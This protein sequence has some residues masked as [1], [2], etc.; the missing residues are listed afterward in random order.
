M[1]D[2]LRSVSK[3]I[4]A[5]Y[6]AWWQSVQE[7]VSKPIL[8]V[9]LWGIGLVWILLL[10]LAVAPVTYDSGPYHEG[11]PV[12]G[13]APVEPNTSATLTSAV[14][15]SQTSGLPSREPPIPSFS[16]ES[17]RSF[18]AQN[19]VSYESIS[20]ETASGERA[21]REMWADDTGVYYRLTGGLSTPLRHTLSIVP[22][23]T[24]GSG[25]SLVSV[26]ETDG[27]TVR[28]YAEHVDT[29]DVAR[30]G[31]AVWNERA[32]AY[33]FDAH[34]KLSNGSVSKEGGVVG[35]EAVLTRSEGG[36]NVSFTQTR[37]KRPARGILEIYGYDSAPLAYYLGGSQERITG[38]VEHATGRSAGPTQEPAWVQEI[39]EG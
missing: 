31:L 34:V 14:T 32:V 13:L 2:R 16:G 27:E 21:T 20:I 15:V 25:I 22:F 11:Q 24:V 37:V 7:W 10:S 38:R 19:N 28:V 8:G 33:Q 36:Y 17:L 9:P 12:G 5:S 1:S 18:D 30:P 6:T 3:S 26:D 29:E 39:R 35:G 23:Q 4:W